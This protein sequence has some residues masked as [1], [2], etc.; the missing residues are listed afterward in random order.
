MNSPHLRLFFALWPPP[1]V[2]AQLDAAAERLHRVRGGRRTRPETIHLTLVF[3]GDVAAARLPEICAVAE[4][5]TTPGFEI[6]F[7]QAN[8]WHHN[9]IAHLGASATPVP[10]TELVQQLE[11]GLDR[12]GIPY[13]R[14]PYLPHITLLRKADCSAQIENPMKNPALEPI[15]WLA[16][17][18][19]LVSSSLRPGWALHEQMGRWPLPL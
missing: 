10:L 13:D 15:R 5:I 11:T 12:V 1:P 6:V 16:R 4:S 8:C 7:D 9:Q 14:R 3:V 18:F 19:V 17:D 2:R